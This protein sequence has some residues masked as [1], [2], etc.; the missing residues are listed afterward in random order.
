MIAGT[1]VWGAEGIGRALLLPYL[2]CIDIYHLAL[3]QIL[4]EKRVYGMG[5]SALSGFFDCG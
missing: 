4:W 3:A 1:T 5:R 2:G